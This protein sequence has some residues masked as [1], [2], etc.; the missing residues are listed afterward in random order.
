MQILA[1]CRATNLYADGLE[2]LHPV[3]LSHTHYNIRI[4]QVLSIVFGHQGG[5]QFVLL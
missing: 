3:C 5:E 2:D 4:K 1:I